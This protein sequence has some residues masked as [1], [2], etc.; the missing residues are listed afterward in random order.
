[1]RDLYDAVGPPDP[2]AA[3]RLTVL[4]GLPPAS[5]DEPEE[6]VDDAA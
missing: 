6:V 1:M 3:R 4:L 2:R 5:S